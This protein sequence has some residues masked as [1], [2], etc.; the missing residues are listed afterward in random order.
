M[1]HVKHRRTSV[2]EKSLRKLLARR[3]Q[4]WRWDCSKVAREILSH[5]IVVKVDW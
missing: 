4:R 3:Y 2:R 1:F 5:I